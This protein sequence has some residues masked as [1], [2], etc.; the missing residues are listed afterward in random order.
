MRN[1]FRIIVVLCLAERAIGASGATFE[2]LHS[3]SGADG[4]TPYSA[5]V[6]DNQNRMYGTTYYGGRYN[7]GT[8]FGF[9]IDSKKLIA[10]HSFTGSDGAA[11]YSGVILDKSGALYGTTTIGGAFDDGT[12]YKLDPVTKALVTLHSFTGADGAVPR[13]ALRLGETG[14]LYGTTQI[15]GSENSGTVFELNPVT[16]ALTTLHMFSGAGDGAYPWGRLAFDAHGMLY[17]TTADGGIFDYPNNLN[18][19]GTVFKIDPISQS[20]TVVKYFN[21]NMTN[22][23]GLYPFAGLIFDPKFGIYG[24]TSYGGEFGY[25]GTISKINDFEHPFRP[26]ITE[27]SFAT[28][29][30]GVNGVGSRE[31]IADKTGMLYG[32]TGSNINY[33]TVFKFDPASNVLTTLYTFTAG[34]GGFYPN[35]VAIDKSGA[36]YGTTQMGGAYGRGTIF[37]I[38]P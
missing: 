35:A 22:T 11:P 37:K 8:V 19:Y 4:Q 31:L 25:Y 6:L 9:I 12:V 26:P 13:A 17:G 33:G 28:N 34:S 38:T 5:I 27:Y 2:T 18:G 1:V 3:F 15:G 10:L 20:F 29:D 36:L 24:T 21:T 14:S 23:G 32:V 16:H 30:S 7:A